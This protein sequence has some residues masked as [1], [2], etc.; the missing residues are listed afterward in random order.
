[1]L[2]P[3]P[4]SAGFQFHFFCREDGEAKP[5]IQLCLNTFSLGSFSWFCH[6]FFFDFLSLVTPDATGFYLQWELSLSSWQSSFTSSTRSSAVKRELSSHAWNNE[7]KE[8]AAK[9]SP[10]LMKALVSVTVFITLP[11]VYRVF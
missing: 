3:S 6:D 5:W 11:L 2:Y 7:G 4:S 8:N 1:M 9:K 10:E